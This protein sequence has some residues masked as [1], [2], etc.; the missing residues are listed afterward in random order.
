[1]NEDYAYRVIDRYGVDEKTVQIYKLNTYNHKAELAQTLLQQ[2]TLAGTLHN[3]DV[4]PQQ[5]VEY[6]IET[7]DLAIDRMKELGWITPIPS[8]Y[9]Q[10][11]G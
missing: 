3:Q 7:A 5:I 11:N 4:T 6:A 9:E 8:P 2:W 10:D 1:M